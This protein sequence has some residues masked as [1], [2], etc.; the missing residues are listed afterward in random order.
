MHEV[1]FVPK[2]AT[3][4]S[5]DDERT[6]DGLERMIASAIADAELFCNQP[7]LRQTMAHP[8]IVSVTA[9][10]IIL[11]FT[12]PMTVTNI[13]T[14]ELPFDSWTTVS[15]ED[16]VLTTRGRLT[17]LYFQNFNPKWEY[18]INGDFGY[19][20]NA[21]DA[22]L[23]QIIVDMAKEMYLAMKDDRFGVLSKAQTGAGI[24]ATTTYIAMREK[25]KQRLERFRIPTV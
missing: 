14:R 11:P 6:I 18:Q 25:F 17:R 2:N 9:G 8:F 20:E 3:A 22:S 15:T 21:F 10:V 16:Y 23:Q 24:A 1:K 12:V 5:T 4:L 13:Q 19:A 7:L